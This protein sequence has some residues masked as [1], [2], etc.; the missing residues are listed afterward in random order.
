[1]WFLLSLSSAF[2][3]SLRSLL[4]KWSLKKV[5]PYILAFSVRVF[6]LPLFTLP[7][8]FGVAKLPVLAEAS[9]NFWIAVALVSFVMTPIEMIFFYKALK[10]EEVSYVVPLLGLSP[11]MTAFF[12]SIFFG[13]YP[14]VIGL[15][16]MMIIVFALYILNTQKKQTSLLDPIKHLLDNKAFKYVM[17]MML[18]YSLGIVVDKSAINSTDVYFY[19]L[20]NY[21][22]VS[23]SLFLIAMFKAKKNFVEIKQNV[24]PFSI[25]GLVVAAYTWLRFLALEKG[26]TGYVS[27]VLSSSVFFSTIF[28]AIIFKEKNLLKKFFIGILILIGLIVIK[29]FG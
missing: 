25:I 26:N 29:V 5:N 11:L 21:S 2:I 9:P 23:F 14:S 1:M 3:Y 12:G 10:M 7:F 8:I 28:G 4:E 19:S 15:L 13:E 17:L 27:A 16:G 6:A 20:V 18:S 24:L 22:L